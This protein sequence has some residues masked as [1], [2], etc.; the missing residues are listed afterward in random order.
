MAD[1]HLLDWDIAA[2]ERLSSGFNEPSELLTKRLQAVEQ[3]ADTKWP[4]MRQESWRRTNPD[5]I[6]GKRFRPW[7]TTNDKESCKNDLPMPACCSWYHLH[8]TH[9]C[10]KVVIAEHEDYSNLFGHLFGSL[11]DGFGANRNSNLLSRVL[12]FPQDDDS[13]AI[14]LTNAAFYQGGFYVTIPERII[15]SRPLW[16]R[17]TAHTPSGALLPLNIIHLGPE[18]EATVMLEHSM[19]GEEESWFGS[20]TYV[21]VEE[22]ARLNLMAVNQSGSAGRFYDNMQ[23]KLGRNA[24]FHFTWAD[25]TE[26]WA[27]VRRETVMAEEGSE[28]V[29]RGVHIG[30]GDGHFDLRTLQ[31]H[32]APNTTSDLL[33]KSVMFDRSKSI[34]QGLIRIEP[35]AKNANAYQLNRNLLMS[36]SSTADSIPML[37]IMVDEVRCT[38][39]ASAGKVDPEALYYMM[40]RGLSEEDATQL[41]IEGFLGEVA[42]QLGEGTLKN[43]WSARVF[44]LS[45]RSL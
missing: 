33:Y 19:M 22:G 24:R 6:G 7:D 17:H 29:L 10:E 23:I 9:P 41:L 26:G 25:L 5:I 34:F 42:D 38:H 39:G 27:V 11:L 36:H 30:R 21:E 40:S 45:R 1:N 4:S 37:E 18:S 28:A 20:T 32:P 31:G 43:Y 12:A 2:A 44:E 8:N 15:V 16:I 13:P 3:L 14:G 35:K